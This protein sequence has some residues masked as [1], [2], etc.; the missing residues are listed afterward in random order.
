MYVQSLLTL[1]RTILGASALSPL[2]KC[3][4]EER[5]LKATIIFKDANFFIKKKEWEK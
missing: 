3:C 1:A 5:M 4:L 2:G